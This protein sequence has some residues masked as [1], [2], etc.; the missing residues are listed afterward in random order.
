VVASESIEF[1]VERVAAVV[2]EVEGKVEQGDDVPLV[3]RLEVSGHGAHNGVRRH[4]VGQ[5]LLSPVE[6][7]QPGLCSPRRPPS[8]AQTQMISEQ[9]PER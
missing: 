1:D 7:R 3:H 8:Q 6:P 4:P 5:P 9:T 2:L